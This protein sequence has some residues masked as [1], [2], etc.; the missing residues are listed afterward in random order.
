MSASDDNELQEQLKERWGDVSVNYDSGATVFAADLEEASEPAA[1]DEDHPAADL[2]VTAPLADTLSGVQARLLAEQAE[3]TQKLAE[4]DEVL[5]APLPSVDVTTPLPQVIPLP[6]DEGRVEWP[7]MQ[8]PSP[9]VPTPP[10]SPS[11]EYT[12]SGGQRILPE[13]MVEE[14]ESPAP[15]HR[16][17]ASTGKYYG[18]IGAAVSVVALV[19]ALVWWVNPGQDGPKEEP[20]ATTSQSAESKKPSGSDDGD[21]DDPPG[22]DAPVTVADDD[23]EPAKPTEQPHPT[24][25]ASATEAPQASATPTRGSSPKPSDTQGGGL[26]TVDPTTPSSKP[27]Y[28]T[29]PKPSSPSPATTPPP[30]TTE[31][32]SEGPTEPATEAPETSSGS[33]EDSTVA[34]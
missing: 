28:T 29:S 21:K 27:T 11:P 32:P 2:S 3:E 4:A 31:P 15:T 18:K 33:S 13:R 10:P 17:P 24:K 5:T 12:T 34:P 14:P 6:E 19:L 26:P 23:T 7:V 22:K 16:R 25:T 30:A 20:K 1:S 9:V 8:T